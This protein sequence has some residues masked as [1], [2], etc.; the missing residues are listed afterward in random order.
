[1][2]SCRKPPTGY[3]HKL[4]LVIQNAAKSWVSVAHS[5]FMYVQLF[6]LYTFGILPSGLDECLDVGHEAI[7][8]TPFS[9]LFLSSAQL[10][11]VVVVG[12]SSLLL[13]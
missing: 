10:F 6:F 3:V 13:G 9:F 2:A 5:D 11:F 8:G 7:S 4:F 12:R 1:M